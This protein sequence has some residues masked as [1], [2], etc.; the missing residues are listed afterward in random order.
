MADLTTDTSMRTLKYRAKFNE[1]LRV[2]AEQSVRTSL[3]KL[4]TLREFTKTLPK[5]R[6]NM[7]NWR[8]N[9][10]EYERRM[11]ERERLDYQTQ[12][13][14]VHD[15]TDEELRNNCGTVGCILGWMAADPGYQQ[16][17]WKT[18]IHPGFGV[19]I[20]YGTET[21]SPEGYSA[22]ASYFNVT[23]DTAAGLFGPASGQKKD[24][25]LD[26]F[27]QRL[28]FV[29]AYCEQQLAVQHGRD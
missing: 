5:E 4:R 19:A 18:V 22:A 7:Q 8:K 13:R 15:V 16:Q 27:L 17:G 26:V 9:V 25:H 21:G 11:E 28:D 6:V 1:I 12:E 14:S 29:I 20:A 2:T 3:I 24:A 10:A 23:L